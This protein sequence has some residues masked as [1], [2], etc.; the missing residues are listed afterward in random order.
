MPDYAMPRVRAIYACVP[1]MMPRPSPHRRVRRSQSMT[2]IFRSWIRCSRKK[3]EVACVHTFLP[4][5]AAP[6]AV[7]SAPRR[8]WRPMAMLRKNTFCFT[9]RRAQTNGQFTLL[10]NRR[11]SPSHLSPQLSCTLSWLQQPSGA[12]VHRPSLGR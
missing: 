7:V 11:L 1:D 2:V 4:L 12:I 9:L 5:N 6:R 8:T 3:K 10:C